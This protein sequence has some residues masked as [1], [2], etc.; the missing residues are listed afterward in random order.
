VNLNPSTHTISGLIKINKPDV[1]IRPIINWKEAPAYKP[2]R[3]LTKNHEIFI[4]LP[5]IFNVKDTIQLMNEV[6]HISFEKE[7]K[8]VSFDITNMYTNIPT[9]ELIE[10]IEIMCKQKDL[11]IKTYNG[12]VQTCNVKLYKIIYNIEIHNTYKKKALGPTSSVFPEIY[13]QYL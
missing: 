12:I 13:L 2:A 1:P 4:P 6:R 5:Y 7:L 9:N 3:K 10:T 11:D 8:F